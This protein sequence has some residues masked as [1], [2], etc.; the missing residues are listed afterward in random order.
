MD[1]KSLL[2]LMCA[3]VA[4]LMKGKTPDQIRKTFNIRSDYTP[5]VI[6]MIKYMHRP[7]H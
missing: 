2:Y 5:Q 7:V 6:S 4:S 3:K 1:V